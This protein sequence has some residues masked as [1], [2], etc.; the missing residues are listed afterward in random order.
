[1]NWYVQT[2]KD[3]ADFHIVIRNNENQ[4]YFSRTIVYNE[5]QLLINI[6]ENSKLKM[7]IDKKVP[8]LELCVLASSST[9]GTSYWFESQCRMLPEDFSKLAKEDLT[10]KILKNNNYNNRRRIN[11]RSSCFNNLPSPL[12]ILIGL[13]IVTFV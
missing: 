13:I 3:I 8:K 1:M 10:K 4:I 2:S 11:S 5:R 9:S 12:Y 6:D 7:A